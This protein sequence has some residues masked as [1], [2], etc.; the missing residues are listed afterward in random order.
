MLKQDS[1]NLAPS[2]YC[3]KGVGYP[4][5]DADTRVEARFEDRSDL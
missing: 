2:A 4:C 3:V 1:A 5:I